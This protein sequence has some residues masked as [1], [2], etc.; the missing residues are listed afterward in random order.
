[1]DRTEYYKTYQQTHKEQIY[2]KHREYYAN[3]KERFHQYYLN[4]IDKIREYTSKKYAEKRVKKQGIII[5]NEPVKISF[6]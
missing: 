1:M 2:A 5:M 4:K 6:N 3:N